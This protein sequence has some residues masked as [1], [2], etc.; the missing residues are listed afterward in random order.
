MS[1]GVP[2]IVATIHSTYWHQGLKLRLVQALSLLQ[3]RWVNRTV[4]ISDAVAEYACQEKCADPD[5]IVVI[6]NGVDLARFDANRIGPRLRCELG[7]G[8]HIRIIGVVGGLRPE[9]GHRYLLDAFADVSKLNP[10][11]H[12]VLIGEGSLRSALEDKARGKGVHNCVHFMGRRT[13][14][15]L[16]MGDFDLL[17]LPS[18]V[19]GFGLVLLEAMA[20][21]LPIVA[22]DLPG[23][24]EVVG[25]DG[26]ALLV[27]PKD[28]PA[29]ALAIDELLT[30]PE[31]ARRMGGVGRTR[32]ER[33]S[34][35]RT[36]AGVEAVYAEVIADGPRTGEGAV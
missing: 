9:K 22:T 27:P 24:A 13:D 7:L 30:L 10:D 31:R 5:R 18:V 32:S 20:L 29:L 26:A 25:R 35:E 23:I 1:T 17:V 15:E 14:V 34:V 11:A 12:L 6:H 19:E 28:P 8:E 33:F 3:G 16:D 4:A 2:R 21:G 36:V